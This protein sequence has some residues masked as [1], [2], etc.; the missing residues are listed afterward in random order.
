MRT[1]LTALEFGLRSIDMAVVQA[2]LEALAALARH[3]QAAVSA[4]AAGIADSAGVPTRSPNLPQGR[5]G[6]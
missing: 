1:L 3:H 5:P 6:V 2:S 4:G